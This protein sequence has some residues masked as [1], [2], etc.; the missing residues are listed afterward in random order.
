M[1]QGDFIDVGFGK[2]IGSPKELVLA[3]LNRMSM[4]IFSGQPSPTLQEGSKTIEKSPDKRE[5]FILAVEFLQSLVMPYY[6]SVMETKQKEFNTNL[7]NK[8]KELIFSSVNSEALE[9]AKKHTNFN[10]GYEY[11]KGKLL[12]DKVI[13]LSKTSSNYEYY[14]SE[15]YKLYLS[16]FQELQFLLFRKKWLVISDYEEDEDAEE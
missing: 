10:E 14:I 1:E 9:L 7:S 8:E 11:W 3:H 4:N 5:T 15:R 2:G 16:L 12:H 13:L 6:D